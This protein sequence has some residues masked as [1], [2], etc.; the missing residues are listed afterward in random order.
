MTP[1]FLAALFAV[2]VLGGATA[3]V[4]GFGI[5]S[6]LT[7]FIATRIGVPMAVAVVAIPHAVATVFRAW[8]LRAAI[9][10]RVMRSFGVASGV[11]GV[12]GALLYTRFSSRTLTLVLGLLLV[13][14]A[15]MTLADVARRWHPGGAA[16]QALGVLSGLFG[17]VAGNQGG[18]RAAALLSFALTPA[19]FVATSTAVGVIVDAARLPIYLLRG[20]SGLFALWQPIVVASAGV[21]VGTL[22]GERVLLG[23][24][25][26][27]FKRVLAA[28]IG[29]LG[30]WLLKTGI[31]D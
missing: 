24:S 1:L 27:T 31:G 6:L 19:A 4:A 2:A 12:A 3:S 20:G 16:S 7:P 21:L 23:L 25:P 28:L 29:A 17:G 26:A 18:L 9:D 15:V 8:R 11:G 10:W 13:T 22:A 5:G 30:L 14:T